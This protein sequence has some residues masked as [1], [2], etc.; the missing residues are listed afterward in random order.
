M[1][2]MSSTIKMKNVWINVVFAIS[3]PVVLFPVLNTKQ[4]QHCLFE[5]NETWCISLGTYNKRA[6][7][8]KNQNTV[9]SHSNWTDLVI[10]YGK[11]IIGDVFDQNQT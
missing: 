6:F 2:L 8:A 9:E 5:C 4:N 10:L 7:E 11:N 3:I 1:T